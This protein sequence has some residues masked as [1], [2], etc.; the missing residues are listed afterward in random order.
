MPASSLRD[1]SAPTITPSQRRC[2]NFIGTHMREKN[3][4]LVVIKVVVAA[5]VVTICSWLAEKRPELAGLIV[6]L[7][8]NAL[9][10][11]EFSCIHSENP[12]IGL[13]FAKGFLSGLTVLVLFF[14]PF[15][16]GERLKISFWNTYA[17]GVAFVIAGFLVHRAVNGNLTSRETAMLLF[18]DLSQMC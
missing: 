2:A 1:A 10:V 3:M 17:L 15:L 4:G 8:L 13:K 18:K 6:V 7:P 12:V 14:V 5:L 16:V 11:L 9:I